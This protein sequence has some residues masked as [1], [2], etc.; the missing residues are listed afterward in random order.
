MTEKAKSSN[1]GTAGPQSGGR[2]TD[3]AT[4]QTTLTT[5]EAVGFFLR[6]NPDFL[7][8]FL[9]SNPDMLL[10]IRPPEGP[11]TGGVIDLRHVMLERLRGEVTRL[12]D[13]QRGIISASRANLTIQNRIHTAAL[14]LLDAE[15]FQQLID[16]IATDLPAMLDLDVAA[17]VIE[18]SSAEDGFRI[19][20]PGVHIVSPGFIENHLEGQEIILQAEIAGD[21]QLYGAAGRQVRSQALVRLTV[22]SETPPCMLAL[23]SREPDMFQEGMRTDLT[24][25]LARIMER[26]IRL[27]LELPE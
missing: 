20:T 23:G 12:T 25:F 26:C 15:S 18:R 19:D 10:K 13:Q 17:L 5:E 2:A 7:A 6:R 11:A 4:P 21:D 22:S 8:E 3:D 1:D 24:A 9:D 14:Q 16:T 27:W